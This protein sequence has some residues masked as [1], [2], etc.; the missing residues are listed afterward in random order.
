MPINDVTEKPEASL[1]GRGGA[2]TQQE[3][4][5]LY[6]RVAQGLSLKQIAEYHNRTSGG[7]SAR[8][9]RLGL[10]DETSGLLLDPLPAFRAFASKDKESDTPEAKRRRPR[11]PS[12]VPEK[13][14]QGESFQKSTWQTSHFL[15]TVALSG[16]D[17]KKEDSTSHRTGTVS[18]ETDRR[19]FKFLHA[20]DLHLDSPLLGLASKSTEY[21]ARIDRASREA[22]EGLIA[23]A[24]AQECDF[25]VLAG[26]IFDGDLRNFGTGLFFIDQLRRLE[27]AGIRAYVILGNHDAENRF[28]TKLSLG[29]NVHL[30]DSKQAESMSLK[31]L[32]V[33]I[34]GRSFPQRDVTQ[35]IARDY[36][37]AIPGQFN[38]GVLHTACQG[39][40]NSHAPY[41]P[42]T[43]EQLANHGY[44]YWALG[45]IHSRA[46]LHEEPYVVY[47]GVLQGRNA[48][49]TGPKG[50]TI[51]AVADGKVSAVTHHELDVVRWASVVVNV[52]RAAT[53][54]ALLNSIREELDR[55]CINAGDR[56]IA[57]RL[58]L[59]GETAL[60]NQLLIE[61]EAL[62]EDVE[63]L[64][65]VL[66][67]DIWLEKLVVNT[68]ASV[69]PALLDPT[70]SGRLAK[71][72]VGPGSDEII[73]DLLESC[74]GEIRSK[75][76]A[77]AYAETFFN[78]LQEEM[79]A[80][81]RALALS[82]I[83][84]TEISD[85]TD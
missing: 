49:E 4:K 48:R 22:F 75:L 51:V 52:G 16:D 81:A 50:A 27:T 63:A 38:I 68:S 74:I 85:A 60:H 57:I 45:H 26:D 13:Y 23:L 71:D 55:V 84:E 37:A 42:C 47:P 20:A 17:T 24:I 80:R 14:E 73:D 32:N 34:H 83:N 30:F 72:I 76:P 39:N 33:T 77:A 64:A 46:V 82:L 18:E 78:T 10:V 21:A 9:K 12:S 5:L 67:N 56:A 6:E 61:P 54:T 28:V 70:V 58:C 79:P 44:D 3:E 62:R 1:P 7:I 36:P 43:V 66:R 25:I 40:E 15:M 19:T 8:L 31:A 2:W 35:N 41:A 65:M 69:M 53:R 59:V 11:P 29:S